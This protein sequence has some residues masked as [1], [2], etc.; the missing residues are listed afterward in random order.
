MSNL[1]LETPTLYSVSSKGKIKEWNISVHSNG[2]GS[3]TIVRRHGYVGAKIQEIEKVISSGKNHGKSNETSPYEQA[4]SEALSLRQ[5]RLDTGYIEHLPDPE[6]HHVELP[7]LAQPFAKSKHR[8]KY[9][10]YVQ[11]KLNGVRCFAKKIDE[12]TITYTSRKGKAYDTLGHLTP[13]LLKE[14]KVGQILDGEI[15]IHGETFQHIVR[16]VKKLRPESKTLQYWVYDIA[17]PNSKFV[18]RHTTLYKMF[19]NGDYGLPDIKVVETKFVD[20]ESMVYTHHNRYVRDGFE[21]VIIRN[22][23]GLYKFD[24]RSADLQKYK[25][26][27]DEEFEIVGGECGTGLHDGCVIFTVRTKDG[28][29]FNVYP[30]GTLER[31]REMYKDI[32]NLV[33]KML[34]IRYQEKSE[35]GIPIFPVGIEVRD[36]E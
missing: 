10:A 27:F 22:M 2:D 3:A 33:G 7:M 16:L 24:N 6:D 8:I 21:G 34:T 32:K 14:M 36:Y 31:R 15:Y 9:P 25:E 19:V 35:D 23:D 18:D 1:K 28:K 20:D 26:F 17:D 29:Q 5:K 13:A 12:N 30:R 4:I 11:P